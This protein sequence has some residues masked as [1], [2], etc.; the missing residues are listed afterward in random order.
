[1]PEKSKKELFEKK[2]V[3]L[4]QKS[5]FIA[6]SGQKYFFEDFFTNV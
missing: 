1:M 6:D 3:F 4:P 2:D 5:N